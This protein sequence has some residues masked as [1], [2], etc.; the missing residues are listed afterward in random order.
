MGQRGRRFD[1]RSAAVV[2]DDHGGDRFP[3][4]RVALRRRPC[5]PDPAG[6]RG[7]RDA[8][9]RIWPARA[10]P[11]ADSISLRRCGAVARH[12]VSSGLR[13]QQRPTALHGP[14]HDAVRQDRP[15]VRA[16]ARRVDRGHPVDN[17]HHRHHLQLP[18][19]RQRA[20][21]IDLAGHAGDRERQLGIGPIWSV[22]STRPSTSPRSVP[23]SRRS[24]ITPLTRR[25]CR[26][27]SWR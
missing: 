6:V 13:D 16:V 21:S 4:R 5:T 9:R 15:A 25:C 23:S 18:P 11:P 2:P 12:A 26:R 20:A 10:D 8:D 19:L 1:R 3:G 17:P 14:I 22:R 24:S 7:D 27:P